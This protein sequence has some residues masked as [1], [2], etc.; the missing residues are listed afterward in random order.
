MTV[1]RPPGLPL[2]AGTLWLIP[3][4]LDEQSDPQAVLPRQTL[5]VIQGLERFVAERPR[6]ARAVLKACGINRPLQSVLMDELNEHTPEADLPRLL[7]PLLEGHSVGLLSEAGCPAV[8]DPGA[9]LVELA[10]RH[11]IPVRPL[12]GPSALL[13]ALMASGLNGQRFAFAGYLP[14]DPDELARSITELEQRSR[15]LDETQ[16]VIET[17]YRNQRL[18]ESFLRHLAADTR[19]LVAAALSTPQERIECREVHVW[20][21]LGTP[22]DRVPTVFGLLAARRL[23]PT[24][25]RSPQRRMR[26][27]G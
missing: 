16:L 18:F 25:G 27:P 12:I 20:R 2:T 13:L 10:H 14:Q 21:T 26:Q 8:A 5:E 17:P 22:T 24:T 3:V 23:R 7:A 9:K 11:G 1:A 19:L 6:S 4:P 15:S